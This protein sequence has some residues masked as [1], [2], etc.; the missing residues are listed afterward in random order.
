[1]EFPRLYFII[2]E[3]LEG[4]KTN[5]KCTKAEKNEGTCGKAIAKTL[6]EK[7]FFFPSFDSKGL[8]IKFT[9]D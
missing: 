5:R 7:A 3:I 9:S 1:M 8:E 2:S 4:K 6:T